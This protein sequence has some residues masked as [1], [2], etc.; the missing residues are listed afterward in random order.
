V[1]ARRTALFTLL[2]F[3]LST[4]LAVAALE[5]ALRLFYPQETLR[6]RW[7]YSPQYCF[8]V[9]PDVRMVHERPGRWRFVYTTNAQRYR[10][11][12]IPASSA[13]RASFVVVLGDS[14]TFGAGVEDDE[15]YAAVLQR[16]LG[17]PY[18]VVNLGIGGWGLTQ[19]I[20]R[21][22]DFGAGYHPRI[23][24][25]QFSGNDPEDDL[26]C[27]VTVLRDGAFDFRDSTQGIYRV[28]EYLSRSIIQRSQI[29]NL[30]RD[31]I[32]RLLASR[33]VEQEGKEMGG[34]QGGADA[35]RIYANLL[36]AFAEDL[37]ARGVRLIFLS[38]N[39]QLAEFPEIAT[40]IRVLEDQG[41]VRSFDA[42]TWLKDV[43][44]YSTP[45]GH[46]WGARAHA[47]IGARLAE[48]IREE[49][50]EESPLSSSP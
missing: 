1:R 25:L 13:D 19:E 32:Y 20:R 6:P 28:K 21:Y 43:Q 47:V 12:L 33:L 7:A 45:E 36:G 17:D 40:Q 14:Y 11:K 24:V 5:I 44:D 18:R 46:L 26:K 10:G 16:A 22:H 15:V 34:E 30:F 39:G 4:L 3:V 50:A 8:T 42:A 9:Y 41:L 29:Y 27:P 37:Q 49:S 48:V 35:A 31:R 23:V 2:G 38:V